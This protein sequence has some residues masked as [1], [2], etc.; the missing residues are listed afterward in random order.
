MPDRISVSLAIDALSESVAA[1]D[2]A[3]LHLANKRAIR[4][5][6]IRDARLNGIGFPRLVQ[7]TGLS[8]DRLATIVNMPRSD[9]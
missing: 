7:V 2:D 9:A 3:V 5:D 4:D 1:V 6:L 8:R